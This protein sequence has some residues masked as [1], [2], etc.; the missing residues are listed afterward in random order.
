MRPWSEL[1]NGSV[2]TKDRDPCSWAE[3]VA[4]VPSTSTVGRGRKD[5]LWT[6]KA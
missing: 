5:F 1:K 6:K 4:E 3:E 2:G